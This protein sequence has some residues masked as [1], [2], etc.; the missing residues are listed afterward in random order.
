VKRATKFQYPTYRVG[1]HVSI[2]DGRVLECRDVRVA[3]PSFQ[4]SLESLVCF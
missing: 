3:W 1:R 4:V 2:L